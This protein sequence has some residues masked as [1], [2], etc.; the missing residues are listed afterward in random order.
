MTHAPRR[1]FLDACV[2]YP[3][4][5]RQLLLGTAEAGLYAPCWSARVLDEWVLALDRKA[6]AAAVADAEEARKRMANSFPDALAAEAASV[7]P[8]LPDPADVHVVA[9]A[10]GGG[11]AELVTFN[12]RD[13]PAR[14]LA[15]LGLVALSP[16]GFLLGQHRDAP[17]IVRG[18]VET[19]LPSLDPTNRRRAL[20]RARLARLGR[21]LEAV[22]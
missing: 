12:L 1:A 10:V 17:G 11:A 16:D 2:L 15:P 7:A 4:L 18:L 22:G 9:A 20:K 19:A 3:P 14:A 5:V 8:S 6:G 13:F 21:A